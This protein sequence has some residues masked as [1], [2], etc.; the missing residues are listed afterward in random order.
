MTR[1]NKRILLIIFICFAAIFL[2][3]GALFFPRVEKKVSA[4]ADVNEGNPKITDA[5]DADLAGKGYKKYKDF[6]HYDG[7]RNRYFASVYFHE[8]LNADT[9]NKYNIF[10]KT[11]SGAGSVTFT[12]G[13]AIL[14]RP[15]GTEIKKCLD[16]LHGPMYDPSD[17]YIN[18]QDFENPTA[19]PINGTYTVKGYGYLISGDRVYQREEFQFIIDTVAPLGTLKGVSNK[20][21]TKTD[22]TFTWSESEATATLDGKAY[23]SGSNISAEGSH[24]IRLTDVAGNI[25]TY[26]FTIDRTAPVGELSGVNENGY[27]VG[28]VTFKWTENNLTAT[29]NGEPYTKGTVIFEEGEKNIVLSDRAGNTTSYSFIIDRSPPEITGFNEYTNENITFSVTEKYSKIAKWE[30]RHNGVVI[31]KTVGNLQTIAPSIAMHGEQSNGVWELRATDI[32]DNVSEWIPIKYVYR[33]TFGNSENIYNKYFIPAFYKVTLSQKNYPSCYGTYE[34]A[35]YGAALSFATAKEWECRVIEL[36]GGKEW[37]YVTASNESA[38]TI[39]TDRAEL[40]TVINKYARANIGERSILGKSGTELNNPTDE[41]GVT[42][43]DALTRQIDELPAVLSEYAADLYMLVP[44]NCS[45]SA[46]AKV[47]EGNST[48]LTVRFISD[49]ISLRE[50]S[51]IN[52]DYGE[53]LKSIISEQGWYLVEESD[54]CGNFERYL[55]YVDVES[56]KITA[57]VTHGSGDIE[58]VV[59]TENYISENTET[60]RYLAFDIQSLTDNIDD[61]VMLN[62]DGRGLSSAMFVSGDTL[63]VLTYENG[64]Y[65]VYTVSI[66]DR[67][68]NLLEFVIYIA[69]EE[70]SL[71]YSSLTND[72]ACTF[73][74]QIN[75]S[76]NE[77]VDVKI[78]KVFYDGTREALTEDS[79]GTAVCADNLI[80]KMTVGGKYVFEF[81]DLYGRIVSTNP[82]FY[83]KGLPT[84]TLRGVR[85]GGVTKNDVKVTY[86][87]TCTVELSVLKGGE[88]IETDLFSISEGAERNTLSIAA[89][90]DTSAVYKLLLYTT[91]DR[92]LFTEYSFEI[93]GI[94]PEVQIRTESGGGVEPETVTTENFYITWAEAGYSVWYR[95]GN[96][97]ADDVYSKDTVIKAAGTYKFTVLDAVRN[98]LVFSVTLD[99]SVDY[100]LDGT[101]STLLENGSYVTRGN[102]I[103]TVLEPWSLFEVRSSNGLNVVNGQKIDTDGTY[104]ISVKDV[105][106]NSL[107]LT[108]IIDKLP[109]VPKI[110]TESGRLVSS[111][112]RINE[113]FSVTCDEENANIKYSSGGGFTAYDGALLGESG[114]YTFTLTDWVGNFVD[115]RIVI[116]K[117]LSYSVNGTYVFD[118]NGRLISKSWLSISLKEEMSDFYILSEDGTE[119]A[120]DKR[121]SA[122]GE[123]EVYM[124]DASGNEIT[125]LLVIDKTPPT[126]ELVGVENGIAVDGAVTV[127]FSDYSSAYYRRNDGEKI[128]VTSGTVLVNEGTYTVTALDLVGNSESV[129]FAIDK[130]VDVTPSRELAD[131][132]IIAGAISFTFNEEVTATLDKDGNQRPYSHGN[133]TELGDYSLM[134]TDNYGNSQTFRWC[135]VAAKAKSYALSMGDC[136]VEITRGGEVYSAEID[137]DVLNL[138]ESGKYLLT[139]RNKTESWTLEL[140]VDNSPPSVQIENTG[141][142]VKIFNPNKEGMTYTLYRDGKQ[143]SFNMGS[144][145]ELTEKGNYKLVCT[146]EVGNVTEYTFSLEYMGTMTIVLIAVVSVLALAAIIALVVI[147]LRHKKY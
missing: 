16:D 86:D 51:R 72:T 3:L 83:L 54:R 114:N 6:F 40:D 143:V 128:S 2:A 123:Y 57:D 33:E 85:D 118:D 74:I 93:D 91:A 129:K 20:G 115:V 31:T 103:F 108:L 68:L 49:G 147:R 144:S 104:V 142:S 127:R 24:T 102:F 39:Y 110:T 47:V 133:I 8:Y 95:K 134:V 94:P 140:E 17:F 90:R 11:T 61:Y 101:T 131:G 77:I 34:F 5:T 10:Y 121:I 4:Y 137:G 64:F 88:W 138:K 136:T 18:K 62:I 111:G 125:L 120:A 27:A 76:K 67:S 87:A 35:E 42:R 135:I 141:K 75:D 26:S 58:E 98:E 50:G 63:P 81:R 100:S 132:Q 13:G 22:V 36:N 80:Y 25:S 70:P 105:Y 78:Y 32:C 71:R 117:M 28:D 65:G 41:L 146:D 7:S 55:L 53:P 48:S 56:P 84:A 96:A 106:G 9:V 73:T 122:V 23:T 60:M 46:P 113:A 37:N 99:N 119:Y 52:L 130:S 139:F 145:A 112:A 29:L 107:S 38:R 30:Y 82:I 19:S 15:D 79:V 45:F 14:V 69:G 21:F 12:N 109:P 126:I 89:G 124:C 97:I 59:F 92:N 66:Y 43:A 116:D 1:L 44:V